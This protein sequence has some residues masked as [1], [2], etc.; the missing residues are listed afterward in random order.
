VSESQSFRSPAAIAVWW[1]W[2]L[3]AVANLIDLAVQGR[4]HTS[5]VAGFVLAFITGVV[6]VT[7]ERPRVR[8]DNGALTILNPLRGHRVSWSS[9][10]SIDTADLLRIRC[11]WPAQSV[12]EDGKDKSSRVIYA[13]AVHGSRRRAAAAEMRDRR[14][15]HQAARHA[16]STGFDL[17]AR[18][19][20]HSG[21]PAP[22]GLDAARI[23]GTLTARAE[24]V[25][26][27]SPDEPATAP[28]SGWDWPAVAAIV[29]PGLALLIAVLA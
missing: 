18:T 16:R 27:A 29:L 13:W 24:Q 5:L 12:G 10:S 4:D 6:Y 17:P 3:F 11:E 26:A 28:V 7:A 1:I 21:P 25:K 2:V 9:V 20:V 23:A 19:P 15:A 22:I 14:R 8:A